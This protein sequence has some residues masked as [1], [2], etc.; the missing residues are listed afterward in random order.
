[1][2]LTPENASD[3]LINKLSESEADALA[4]ARIAADLERAT[5]LL[6]NPETVL[7]DIDLRGKNLDVRYE[8]VPGGWCAWDANTYDGAPDASELSRM[9]GYGPEKEDALTDLLEQIA[10]Y[11]AEHPK[12]KA[13][14]TI[15]SSRFEPPTIVDGRREDWERDDE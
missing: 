9:I 3:S 15:H 4:H 14:R 6:G 2:A 12:P 1:M 11:A 10:Q 8:V 5:R 13:G 7:S